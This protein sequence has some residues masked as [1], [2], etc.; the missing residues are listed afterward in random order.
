M[1]PFQSKTS[2]TLFVVLSLALLITLTAT[3]YASATPPTLYWHSAD[4]GLPFDVQALAV[5]PPATPLIQPR[6]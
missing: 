6:P 3:L 2:G 5:A 4:D 1:Q